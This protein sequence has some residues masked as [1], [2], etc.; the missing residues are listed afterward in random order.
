MVGT[1]AASYS[2]TVKPKASSKNRAIAVGVVAVAIAVGL[3]APTFVGSWAPLA[4]WTCQ[5]Q[6]LVAHETDR[7]IPT[8]LVNSPYLGSASGNGSM[9]WAFPGAWN[10]P[11]PPPGHMLRI[12]WGTSAKNGTAATA[13]FTAN[14]SLYQLGNVTQWGPGA[15]VRCAQPFAIA[16]QSPT[17]YAATTSRIHTQSNLS[18]LG[19]ADNVSAYDSPSNVSRLAFINNSF[20]FSNS[21]NIST[22]G[23]PVLTR[24]FQSSFLTIDVPFTVAG[25]TIAL[26]YVLPFTESFNY[27]FPAN[28]GVWQVD[29]LA[30][31]P[32]AP[33]GGWAF[34]YLP[35]P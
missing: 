32:G 13:L 1:P 20:S 2:F 18:D 26:P 27:T 4:H 34:S 12:G 22:C 7:W 9:D 8:V 17:T 5:D 6:A 19:E 29:N 35:C 21:E 25:R 28:G 23:G 15:N 31:G 3:A 30:T 24:P 10:G 33:G 11:P 16:F 14:A